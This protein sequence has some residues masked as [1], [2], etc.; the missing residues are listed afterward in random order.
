M[1]NLSCIGINI[2]QIMKELF[3]FEDAL[4]N[5]YQRQLWYSKTIVLSYTKSHGDMETTTYWHTYPTDWEILRGK[6]REKK[7]VRDISNLF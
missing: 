1:N 2:D 4:A 7:T 3:W 6:L 5:G